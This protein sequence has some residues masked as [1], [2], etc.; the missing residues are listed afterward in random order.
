MNSKKQMKK[1][2]VLLL[3]LT[4]ML[5][6]CGLSTG[7][8]VGDDDGISRFVVIERVDKYHYIVADKVTRYEYFLSRTKDSLWV[9]GGNVLDDN[10]K[11]LKFVGEFPPKP[12]E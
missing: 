1:V 12:K 5:T 4:A 10:G 7:E 9:V 2:I 3:L 8:S 11:P 6:G